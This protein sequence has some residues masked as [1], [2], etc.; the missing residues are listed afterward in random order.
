MRTADLD[1][2]LPGLRLVIQRI[3]QLLQRRHEAVND[4]LRA[5]DVHRRGIGV[6]RRLAHIDVVVGMDGLLRTHLAAQHLDGAIRDHLVRVH[7]RL[8]ARAGL[9]DDEG[10]M[11]VQVSRDHFLRRAH[12]RGAKPLI[13]M[14]QFH[15]GFGGRALDDS[16]RPHD[17]EGLPL[18]ADFEIAKRTLGLRAP[19]T[20]GRDFDGAK[21]VGLGAGFRHGFPEWKRKSPPPLREGR[22]IPQAARYFLR[23]LSRL[24]ICGLAGG[25]SAAFSASPG[26]IAAGT[27]MLLAASFALAAG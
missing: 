1:D 20:V 19:I 15:I 10:E 11:I 3:A 7:V 6:V 26:G 13:E 4:F 2:V 16:Q 24:T 22:T 25:L 5:G 18:Q 8:S 27:L 23:N 12:D 14:P 21:R 17:R 9:P